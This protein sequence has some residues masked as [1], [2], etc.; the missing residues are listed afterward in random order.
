MAIGKLDDL[1]FII[2]EE[3]ARSRWMMNFMLLLERNQT[4]SYFEN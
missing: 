1:Y 3:V 2:I 4:I